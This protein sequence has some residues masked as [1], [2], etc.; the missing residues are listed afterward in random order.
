[1]PPSHPEPP[2]QELAFGELVKWCSDESYILEQRAF[3]AVNEVVAR[4]D[5]K[6]RL[7][8]LAAARRSVKTVARLMER[9]DKVGE[10][11]FTDKHIQDADLD[12]LQR[13]YALLSN[14]VIKHT[15]AIKRADT[16]TPEQL[17]AAF[18]GD[19]DKA[20]SRAAGLTPQYRE[21]ARALLGTLKE[22]PAPPLLAGEDPGLEP[23]PKTRAA[24]AAK[25]AKSPTV[26]LVSPP[27]SGPDIGPPPV[28]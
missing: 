7:F 18:K 5:V 14:D 2:R 24:R 27:D 12:Q 8:L 10:A 25:P 11:L 1:M 15:E 3:R 20:P 21:M 6:L 26:V 4:G 17:L 22:L 23:P 19:D 9:F 16:V 28:L 13:M